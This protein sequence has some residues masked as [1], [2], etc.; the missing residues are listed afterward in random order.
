MF[1]VGLYA[2]GG[3]DQAFFFGSDDFSS[4]NDVV[5]QGDWF[6]EVEE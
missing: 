4:P 6:G 2:V 5:G 1:R 3:E